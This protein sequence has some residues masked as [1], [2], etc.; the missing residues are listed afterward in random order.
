M[1]KRVNLIRGLIIILFICL[2]NY[3][4]AR[5]VFILFAEYTRLE[6]VLAIC[7][8]LAEAFVMFHA[9]G[10]FTN[11]YRRNKEEG[12]VSRPS[13]LTTFP[14]VAILIP[15]RHEPKM[16]LENTLMACHNLDYPNKEIY[17]LDDSSDEVYKKDAEE[18]AKIYG[19]KLFRR[20]ERHGA[21]AG[22]LNDCIKGLSQKYITVFDVDQNPISDFLSNIIPILEADPRLA[23]VQTPQFYSN[24][25]AN[26]V[27]FASN[28]QQTVFYEYISEGKSSNQAM[29]CCGTNVVLRRE[30][31]LDVGGFDE[32][33]VTEDFA[34]SLKMHLKG[35]RSLYYNHV[36]TF[37]M[38]PEDLGSYFLQQ[39]RW[40]MGNIGVFKRVVAT[41]IKRPL[42]LKPVQWFEYF[43]TGSYYFIGWAYIFLLLCPVTY[44]V[45][46]VPSFF[47]NPIVYTFTFVPY[48]IL[49]MAIFYTSMGSKRYGIKD[50]FKGQL[51]SFITLPIYMRASL[52]GVSGRKGTFQVTKKG[53]TKRISY[54]R[55]WPQLLIW[56]ICLFSIA[57]GINRF[58]YE[59]TAAIAINI[60]WIS[61][62]YILLSCIFY[63]NDEGTRERFCKKL[64][65]KTQFEYKIIEGPREGEVLDDVNWIDYFSVFLHERLEA[66]TLVMCKVRMPKD[67]EDI[68]FD[69]RVT[70]A[71]PNKTRRG[72]RTII[73]VSKVPE[74]NRDKLMEVMK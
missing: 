23:F 52:F 39:N 73:G 58:I 54:V 61:Y 62:H 17:I 13:P 19:A 40:A 44:L 69:G 38:G 48:L 32:T 26:A 11:V 71:F 64:L 6:K 74:H 21:K 41:M 10:Y 14:D 8:F 46:N 55:L 51:L 24:L 22:V 5:A 28:M 43:V 53:G 27:S 42:A 29:I 63:F 50:L 9:F 35:W 59:P 70:D 25:R 66:G 36:H 45:F 15:A 16:V 18:L 56:A 1:I 37:G 3:F 30:A 68:V 67:N 7:F 2:T 12:A 72:Y 31:L 57:W 33:S 60:T 49:S 20:K 47:M 34:T 4:L 65:K